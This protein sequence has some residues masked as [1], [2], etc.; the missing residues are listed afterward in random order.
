V[1][2]LELS[3]CSCEPPCGYWE[4]NPGALEKQPPVLSSSEASHQFLY[5]LFLR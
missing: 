2:L 4:L 1:D 3:F 5:F